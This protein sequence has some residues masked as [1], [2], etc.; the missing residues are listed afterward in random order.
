MKKEKMNS[1][2]KCVILIL[3][4]IFLVWVWN[5]MNIYFIAI[6]SAG[7]SQGFFMIFFTNLIFAIFMYLT[8]TRLAKK[9]KKG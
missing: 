1:Y 5:S 3:F 7:S 8:F 6:K 4:A 9:I 2:Q